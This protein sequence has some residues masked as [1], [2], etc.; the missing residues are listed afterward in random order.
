MVDENTAAIGEVVGEVNA[1]QSGERVVVS[2]RS[3]KTRRDVGSQANVKRFAMI[4]RESGKR[5][6]SNPRSIAEPMVGRI[7]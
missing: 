7:A 1:S 4:K 5:I 3:A 6:L 2:I